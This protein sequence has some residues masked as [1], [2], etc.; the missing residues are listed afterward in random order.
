[1]P[2]AINQ[3][4]TNQKPNSQMPMTQKPNNQ[5]QSN[6]LP[7]NQA[8]GLSISDGYY[9]SLGFVE[10]A[11]L[12]DSNLFLKMLTVSMTTQDPTSPTDSSEFMNQ[13]LQYATM[14]TLSGV[15]SSL[16]ELISINQTTNMHNVINSAISL[17]G[18]NVTMLIPKGTNGSTEDTT[19]TG[20][21]DKVSLDEN[22]IWVEIDG[23]KY[24]YDNLLST[25]K[26]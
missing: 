25:N 6:Q 2:I 5:T 23:K 1:M 10:N 16:N 13:M 12:S 21:V 9:N 17:T 4:P 24:E 26:N 14:E 7:S 8:P 22:G 11:T 19:V 20:V 15:T 3:I 18:K